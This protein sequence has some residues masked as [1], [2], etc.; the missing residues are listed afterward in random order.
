MASLLQLPPVPHAPLRV[1]A[2]EEVPEG[3]SLHLQTGLK[4][5]ERGEG[6]FNGLITTQ[7]LRTQTRF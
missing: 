4:D 6:D 7:L 2:V 3:E 5:S 1:K